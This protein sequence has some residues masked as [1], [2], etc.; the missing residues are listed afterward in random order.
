[1][2]H[3]SYAEE[4]YS[5]TRRGDHHTPF[6]LSEYGHAPPTY[7]L[8][9]T[10]LRLS[11]SSS[12]LLSQVFS[13][14]ESN[15]TPYASTT[16]HRQRNRIYRDG[17]GLN[18]QT[19]EEA[20]ANYAINETRPA[21]RSCAA[22]R[23]V[24]TS[25]AYSSRASGAAPSPFVKA[26]STLEVSSVSSCRW[27]FSPC[28][29]HPRQVRNGFSHNQPRRPNRIHRPIPTDTPKSH[30]SLTHKSGHHLVTICPSLCRRSSQ[31][32]AN[33]LS[34]SATALFLTPPTRI[35]P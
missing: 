14:A 31:P 24:S 5:S 8:P 22:A 21:A 26:R 16:I 4:P 13:T 11:L 23:G 30:F 32:I 34:V 12:S 18:A 17:Q 1:V 25:S 7:S 35:S 9:S 27:L 6:D 20:R 15:S 28:T 10:D 33:A 19:F 29:L 3:L 2:S